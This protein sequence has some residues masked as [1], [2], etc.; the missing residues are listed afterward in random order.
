VAVDVH[1][2][3]NGAEDGNKVLK[4]MDQAGLEKI[5]LFSPYPGMDVQKQ[6]QSVDQVL[7]I[8]RADPLRIVAFAWI[9]PRLSGSGDQIRRAT[10]EGIRGVKMIPMEWYPGGPEARAVYEVVQDL[11]IPLLMHSGILWGFNTDNSQYCRPVY[12]EAL[13]DYPKIKFALAHMS[14]PWTDECLAVC[15]KFRAAQQQE[16]ER[17][18]QIFVDITSGAPRAWKVDVMRKALI[19]LGDD[20]FMY[21]SDCSNAEDPQLLVRKLQEDLSILQTE[22]GVTQETQDKIFSGNAL[23]FLEQ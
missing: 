1:I 22:V 12:Y 5:I 13:L 4:A 3:S 11:R 2:H 9:E 20:I 18:M 8:S 19:F 17:I 14:W 10:E 7:S 6:R 21:G 15:G 16:P 23:R